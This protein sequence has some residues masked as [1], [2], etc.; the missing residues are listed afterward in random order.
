AGRQSA[1][2]ALGEPGG[3]PAQEGQGHA[4]AGAD[5]AGQ[6]IVDAGDLV[7]EREEEVDKKGVRPEDPEELPIGLE[8]GDGSGLSGVHRLVRVETVALEGVEAK[9]GR[10]DDHEQ[11]LTG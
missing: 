4:K 10:N 5:K 3:R 11:R 9:K 1:D 6:P 7:A 8:S 2:L